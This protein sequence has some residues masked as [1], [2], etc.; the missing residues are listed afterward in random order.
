MCRNPAVPLR[1]L[2]YGT[3]GTHASMT[4]I[5]ATQHVQVRAVWASQFV[6]EPVCAI[7]YRFSP[8]L[9]S[10]MRTID[11]MFKCFARILLLSGTNRRKLGTSGHVSALSFLICLASA[12]SLHMIDQGQRASGTPENTRELWPVG[13]KGFRFVLRVLGFRV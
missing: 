1:T 12:K 11:D 5:M 3:Y 8:W 10:L 7:W 4:L 13:A 6:S 2:N 9:N